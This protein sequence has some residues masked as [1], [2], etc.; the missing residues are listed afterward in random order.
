MKHQF[1]RRCVLNEIKNLG[2]MDEIREEIHNQLIVRNKY[3][4][5]PKT[6]KWR[7]V[8]KSKMYHSRGFTDFYNRFVLG[9]D[10]K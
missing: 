6:S 5:Y 3:V 9:N 10:G 4:F 7:V 2:V 8:G 1:V